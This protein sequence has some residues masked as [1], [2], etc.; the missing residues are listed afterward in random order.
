MTERMQVRWS[1]WSA[2][3]L[4]HL[5]LDFADAG[6]R[7]EAVIVAPGDEA[8]ACRYRVAL[9][10]AWRTRSVEVAV[11]GGAS[12]SL[13]GDGEGRWRDDAGAGLRDLDGAIDIDLA[14]SP[15]TN[16]LPIRRLELEEGEA[17]D[18]ETVY[19]SFPDL[20]VSRDPQRYTCLEQGRLYR[21]ASRDSDFTR[22]IEVDRHGLVVTYPGLFRRV[23]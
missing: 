16:T 12:R 11:I 8:F 10:A 2:T 4:E 17:R 23:A 13:T 21:F 14:A 5:E 3:G 1:D 9:D 7:A 20:A 19:F 22:D 6:V 18:I 15:F